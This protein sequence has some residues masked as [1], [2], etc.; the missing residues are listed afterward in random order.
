[1]KPKEFDCVKLLIDKP[2]EGLKIGVIGVIVDIN[3]GKF[4]VEFSDRKG[5][6]TALILLKK[7]EFEIV[8]NNVVFESK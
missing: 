1:M 7:F 6:T 3:K 2:D 4:L 5:R 8:S